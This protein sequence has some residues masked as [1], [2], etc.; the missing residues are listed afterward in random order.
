MPE[1]E[2]EDSGSAENGKRTSYCRIASWNGLFSGK[3]FCP[4]VLV[5]RKGIMGQQVADILGEKKSR[6]KALRLENVYLC[7]GTVGCDAG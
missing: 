5:E 7:L 4:A 2:L 1:K 3:G 6:D